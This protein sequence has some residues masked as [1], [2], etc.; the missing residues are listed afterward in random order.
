M[1]ICFAVHFII[2]NG[3]SYHLKY[4]LFRVDAN[5]RIGMGH[6]SRCLELAKKLQKFNIMPY[7]LIKDNV[8]A[9]ELINELGF[10]FS[11]IPNTANDQKEYSVLINLHRKIKFKCLFLDI[12][13]TKNK[14]FFIKLKK[15][16]QT[17]VMDNTNKNSLYADLIIWPWVK[18]Q[19]PKDVITKNRQK[20]IVGP[21]YML[22]GSTKRSVGIKTGQDS[23]LVS[24]GGSDKLGF[25]TKI[26]KS[27]KK[28]KVKFHADVVVGRFFTDGQKILKAVENDSRFTIINKSNDLISIMPNYKIGIFTFGITT[29]EAF[30]AGLPS[31]VLSHSN[32]NN[33]YAKKMA[34]YDCMKY[35]GYHKAIN[36]DKLPEVA[37][38]LMKNDGLCKK[39]RKNGL[40]LIDGKGSER[41][42]KK[43]VELMKN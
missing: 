40:N 18:E 28:N 11:T 33:N 31:L 19:Y 14:E 5:K 23:I 12:K 6:L 13:K 15:T 24:M 1:R 16:C 4:V 35:L 20:I 32:E 7:F 29:C 43:I 26:I 21:R 10:Q 25:T 34:A 3:I 42:A 17:I 30:F 37:F 39:Y 36:F 41:I 27:F 8:R 2:D 38:A 22:L 9:T